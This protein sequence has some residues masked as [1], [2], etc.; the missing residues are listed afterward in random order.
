MKKELSIV[1]ILISIIVSSQDYKIKGLIV[2]SETEK[3]IEYVNIGISNKGVG[4]VSN[5]NGLFSLKFH[6][7]VKKK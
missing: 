1:F 2:D 7:N 3:T 5:E 4:T 6:V